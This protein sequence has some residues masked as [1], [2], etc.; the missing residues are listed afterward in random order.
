MAGKNKQFSLK[1]R[2][3][4]GTCSVFTSRNQF[5]GTSVLWVKQVGRAR[6]CTFLTEFQQTNFHKLLEGGFNPKLCSL[7]D[8]N[9]GTRKYFPTAKKLEGK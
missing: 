9:L 6:S 2:F 5:S 8:E 7:L 4:S 3:E 1:P